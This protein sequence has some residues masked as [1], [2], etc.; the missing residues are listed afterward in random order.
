MKR[1]KTQRVYL[2]QRED[3][4]FVLETGMGRLVAVQSYTQ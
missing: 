4:T 3:E 1:A 2:D